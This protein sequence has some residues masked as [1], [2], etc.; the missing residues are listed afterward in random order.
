MVDMCDIQ[1]LID[2][3]PPDHVPAVRRSAVSRPASPR[4]RA[5][6]RRRPRRRAVAGE[7]FRVVADEDVRGRRRRRAPRSR[8]TWRRRACPSP[9]RIEDLQARAAARSE[10]H[11]VAGGFAHQRA[12]VVHVAAD[13]GCRTAR[14]LAG[15]CSSV[16][17][18]IH[19]TGRSGRAAHVR[20]DV[21]R[22]VI[23]ARRH[24]ETS[25]GRRRTRRRGPG[26]AVGRNSPTSTRVGTTATRRS[27]GDAPEGDG[28]RRPDTATFMRDTTRT[29]RARSV[30]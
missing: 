4:R 27:G 14:M 15:C 20:R 28:I 16:A 26:P 23:G 11:D 8:S 5:T 17:L 21:G 30:R 10:R 7:P 18:P 3:I 12:C 24:S 25:G 13:R 2:E 9:L 1:I 22:E 19:V 29:T 6:R